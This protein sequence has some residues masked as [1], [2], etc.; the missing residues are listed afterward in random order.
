M[1]RI[2]IQTRFYSGSVVVTYIHSRFLFR[3][4]H[5]YPLM[6]FF[7]RRR[8]TTFLHPSSPF[9]KF[10]SQ[11]F[12]STHSSL[13]RILNL[14]LR[15]GNLS[16]DCYSIFPLLSTICLYILTRDER[17]IYRSQADLNLEPKNVSSPI[18]GY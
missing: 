1:T 10:R 4:G 7:N 15:G 17:G 8:P 13:Y 5:W 16:S 3:R 12:T 6:V 11:P 9:H 14:E 2:E 18:F